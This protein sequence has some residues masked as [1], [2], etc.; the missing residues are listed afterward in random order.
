MKRERGE[1]LWDAPAWDSIWNEERICLTK[2]E[3]DP[4]K[5]KMWR[6]IDKLEAPL[7]SS[8]ESP[9]KNIDRKEW[10]D[11]PSIKGYMIKK[12]ES[13]KKKG[14]RVGKNKDNLGR[15][16]QIPLRKHRIDLADVENDRIH[17]KRSTPV[18]KELT[19]Q[20]QWSRRISTPIEIW[21]HHLGKVWIQ[22]LTLKQLEY[23][24]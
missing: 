11:F 3:L 12:S 21:E 6:R 16:K 19:W 20:P 1:R 18:G 13:L 17:L 23:H 9:D 2:L 10:R 5:K 14:G 7:V 15:M 22:H 4:P 24:K 8:W